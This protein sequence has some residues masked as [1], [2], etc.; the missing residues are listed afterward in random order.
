MLRNQLYKQFRKIGDIP[1]VEGHLRRNKGVTTYFF[2]PSKRSE[3][4]ALLQKEGLVVDE[5][6][7]WMCSDSTVIW[8]KRDEKPVI[9]FSDTVPPKPSAT[10]NVVLS[11]DGSVLFV[12]VV[13]W[14]C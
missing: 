13:R 6:P 8:R 9:W 14:P 11:D 12:S 5:D 1:K 7:V 10:H 3:V 2:D 4:E